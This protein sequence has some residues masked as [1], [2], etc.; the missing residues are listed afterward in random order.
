M[1]PASGRKTGRHRVN[2]LLGI[3]SSA[4]LALVANWGLQKAVFDG[5][6][7]WF[8]SLFFIGFSSIL[9]AVNYLATIVK[10]R[11]P[12]MTMFRMP[13]SIWSLFIT[14]ILVL[15]AT[16][17]LA[18]VLLM[19]LL[20]HHRLTSF[21]LPVSWIDNNK[22]EA[23]FAGNPALP[24]ARGPRGGPNAVFRITRHPMMWSFA[25]WAAV[26]L[27]ILAMPKAM[28]FDGAIILLAL[29]VQRRRIG[30]R[31][32]R[33]VKLGTNGLRRPPLSPSLGGSLIQ[34]PWLSSAERSCS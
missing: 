5:Q 24:G 4:G 16:P 31:P 27:T 21:F 3:V 17:V 19:N 7:A 26:H 32:A 22:V 11:C 34:E 12:G 2:W 23:S 28:V 8:L 29:A 15:L 6:S 10:L 9:G 20:E 33:W 25:L 18:S 30:R 1:S 14:S 13:L